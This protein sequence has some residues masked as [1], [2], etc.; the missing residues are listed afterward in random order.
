[1]IE[2]VAHRPD[3]HH[4]FTWTYHPRMRSSHAVGYSSSLD[5]SPS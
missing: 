2:A 4:L 5:T 1:M 3:L